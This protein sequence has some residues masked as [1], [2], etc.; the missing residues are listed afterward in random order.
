MRQPLSK[1]RPQKG[2][3]PEADQDKQGHQKLFRSRVFS[4]RWIGGRAFPE[5]W[6]GCNL[7]AL[8][9]NRTYRTLD[10]FQLQASSEPVD[11]V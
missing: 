9:V 5:A 8:K 6:R 4:S 2:F 1:P 11:P 7:A 3:G 10:V